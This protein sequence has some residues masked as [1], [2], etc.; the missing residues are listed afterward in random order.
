MPHLPDVDEFLTWAEH[1]RL[2][3]PHTLARYRAVLATLAAFADPLAATH[4]DL[5]AW[6]DSR[7][8]IT[9]PDGTTRPRAASSRTNELA[10]LRAYYKWAVK[11]RHRPDDPSAHLDF[12]DPDNHLPRPI[13]QTD[14]DRLLGPLTDDAPDLRRAYALGAYGGLRVSEA[15]ALD[16]SNVVTEA[17][18]IYVR[19]KGRRERVVGLSPILL[20]KLLPDTG[21]NVVTAGGKPYSGP[22][23]QRKV[24]RL[25]E[26][27]GMDRRFHDLRKRGASL[28]L[29][30]GMNPVA[31][32]QVFGWSSMQTVTHYAAVGSEEIDRVAEAMI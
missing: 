28:A 16:W 24:N 7:I 20:D 8:T 23:L 21:G 9:D 26:Q 14:L 29:A 32:R 27:A 15:A 18:R 13:G 5:Q 31:V 1:D 3:S 11:K 19:G 25:M 6:W 30:R 2:R 22:T 10:C 4:D 17:R 12:L